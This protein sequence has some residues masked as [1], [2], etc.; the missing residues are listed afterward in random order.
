MSPTPSSSRPNLALLTLTIF[1]S[2]WQKRSL[3]RLL[4]RNSLPAEVQRQKQAEVV[5]L[6][7]KA[8]RQKRKEREIHFSKKYHKVRSLLAQAPI[9]V[10]HP[11]LA[12]QIK[13]FE[14]QK[15]ERKQKAITRKL[16]DAPA[17]SRAEFESDSTIESGPPPPSSLP[18]L[19]LLSTSPPMPL[20]R[21]FGCPRAE[22]GDT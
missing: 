7:Q 16:E 5:I 9:I 14:R 22:G 2:L 20:R 17:T 18:P 3:E 10:S 6:E 4:K 13:F 1:T 11:L 21:P 19:L 15:V 8:Q 12:L